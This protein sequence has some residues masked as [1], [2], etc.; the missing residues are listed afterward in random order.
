[1][2]EL[3]DPV[4]LMPV[5]PV[6]VYIYGTGSSAVE[7]TSR[8]TAGMLNI[9]VMDDI[10]YSKKM[11]QYKSNKRKSKY[12][13]ENWEDND[14]KGYNLVLQHCPAELEARLKNQDAWGEV[15]DTRSVVRLL[16][17]IRYL[18]YNKT[19]RKRSIMA[20]VEADFELFSRCQKKNQ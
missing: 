3:K 6:R 12:S 15:E 10:D 5:R 1:M 13:A 18:Q 4:F 19:D 16:T 17:L 8:L 11:D 20:T 9:E 14:A 7:T 2:I